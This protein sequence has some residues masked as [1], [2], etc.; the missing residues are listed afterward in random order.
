[1]A[2]GMTKY[3]YL[4]AGLII[5]FLLTGTAAFAGDQ[6][7]SLHDALMRALKG[8]PEIKANEQALFAVKEDITIAR[9]FLLPRIGFEERF[10]R[11]NNPTYAFMA[12]LNQ[13]RFAI[14]DFAI[15]SLNNPEPVSDFQTSVSF[16][17]AV[18]APKAY[19]GL[20]MSRK[21][22]EAKGEDVERKREEVVFSVFRTYLDSQTARAFVSVA[23]KG[24]EDAK[25]HLRIAESRN[26]VGLGLYS[27]MLRAQVALRTAEERKISAEKNMKVAGR[28]IGLMLGLTESISVQDQRPLLLLKDLQYYDIMAQ[29]RKDLRAL[30]ARHKNAENNLKLANASYLPTVGL[31]GTYQLNSHKAVFGE[32]GQSWQVM[33]FLRWELF[34]GLR[35][36][37]E[38]NKAKYKL[39]EA[40]EYLEGMKKQI[41]F[42]VYEAYLSVEEARKGLELAKANLASAEEGRRLVKVRYENSLSAAVD[43]LDAQAS[44]DAVRADVVAKEAAYLTAIARLSYQSGTIMKDLEI[45]R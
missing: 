7:L 28:A 15:P 38:R 12:K 43:M 42:A 5:V 20:K 10:M 35:R 37:A 3:G 40:G 16:E 41:S 30:E 13:E 36:E 29:T 26:K 1:G 2:A 32:E 19:I 27:D 17:Q 4:F 6:V 23:E 44:L 18:F 34:D 14:T 24:I 25:E 31:G 21:E 8:N 22:F 11:T 39:A 33:A 45:E 9:S